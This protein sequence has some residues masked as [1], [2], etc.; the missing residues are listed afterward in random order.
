MADFLTR[1]KVVLGNISTWL[2]AAAAVISI[3]AEEIVKVL[4]EDWEGSVSQAVVVILGV[5]TAAVAIIRR[6][7]P[8]IGEQ[9]GLLPVP[10]PVIPAANQE[11]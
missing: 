7:T 8:V 2:I 3:F 5:I 6:V 1:V 10:G 4:P 9:Q 11:G